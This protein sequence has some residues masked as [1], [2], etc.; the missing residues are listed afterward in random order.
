VSTGSKEKEQ[1]AGSM[2]KRGNLV[3]EPV[4]IEHYGS[5]GALQLKEPILAVYL[6]SH[7]DQQHNPW[8]G[9][10]PFWQR[11]VELY[12]PSRGFGLVAAWQDDTMVGYAFGSPMSRPQDIW[13]MV[14]RSLPDVSVQKTSEPIYFFREFA[15]HPDHQG[16]GYGKLLHDALLKTRPERLAH[17][18]VR[19]DNPAKDAYQHWGWHIVGQVQP[20]SDAPVMDAM[21]LVL[22]L[23]D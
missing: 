18:L 13:Q 7:A 15:V 23:D 14:R 19:Q 17:L 2:E 1:A 11:L 12:A 10:G 4:R 22:R 21:V 8:F 16:K 20:F 9:P 5:K 3:P 6:T